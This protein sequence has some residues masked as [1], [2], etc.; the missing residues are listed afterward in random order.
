[1]RTWDGSVAPDWQALPP[2]IDRP[3]KV[4]RDD[5][6]FGFEVVEVE[7]GGVRD[8]RGAGSVDTAGFDLREQ[9]CFE[10]VA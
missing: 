3:L 1:M 7:T 6:G 4:E 9:A 10:A 8:A 5:Q 2:L